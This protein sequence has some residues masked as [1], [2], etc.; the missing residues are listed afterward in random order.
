MFMYRNTDGTFARTKK[1]AGKGA[2]RID[3]P[4]D[5]QGL[6]D[7]LNNLIRGGANDDAPD[8]EFAIEMQGYIDARDG[9]TAC[10]YGV[11]WQRNAWDR[12]F[13]RAEEQGVAQYNRFRGG[14]RR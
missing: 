3:V 9:R 8:P 7:Y 5:A 11:P 1:Q 14:S 10:P 12:G 13:A 4:T 2:E 6:V